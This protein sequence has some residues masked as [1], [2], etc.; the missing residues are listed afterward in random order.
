[1]SLWPYLSIV[2]SPPL[3]AETFPSVGV[4]VQ[5]QSRLS[6][7]EFLRPLPRV[8]LSPPVDIISLGTPFLPSSTFFLEH[9]RT[10]SPVKL[11][12]PDHV[13]FELSGIKSPPAVSSQRECYSVKNT[14]SAPHHLLTLAQCRSP[15]LFH[16][17]LT[18]DHFS[19][20][21]RVRILRPPPRRMF[22]FCPK[23]PPS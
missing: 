2:N 4:T 13:F 1:V 9:L 12:N 20:P 5:E 18:V 6:Q 19:V 7:T 11:I 15:P 8:F 10:D 17:L 23:V 22:P 14:T 21:S 3:L 16:R